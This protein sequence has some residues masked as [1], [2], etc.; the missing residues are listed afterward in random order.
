VVL[1]AGRGSSSASEAA[2]EQ[3][4]RT[5]WPPLYAYIRR[6]GYNPHDAQDLTQ[7]FFALLL[8]KNYAGIAEREK[9]KFRSFLL[10]ALNYFLNGERDRANAAKRGGGRLIVSLDE[11]MGEDFVAAEPASDSTPEKE[12]QKNW[13][14]IVLRQALMRLGEESTAGGKGAVFE[15][16]KPFLEG[17]AKAGDYATVAV[18]LGMSANGVAVAV[19]RLRQRYGELVREEIA[20]TVASPGEVDAELRHLFTLLG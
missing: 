10:A 14:I 9:G 12:F 5:Y 16:L 6:Q 8:E 17:E 13:A 7:G 4:C 18:R 3:L 20:H 2:L 19:H 11:R 1:A 15:E